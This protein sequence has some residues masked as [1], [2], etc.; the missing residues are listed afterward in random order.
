MATPMH[1]A[2]VGATPAYGK[3]VIDDEGMDDMERQLRANMQAQATAKDDVPMQDSSD[4]ARIPY[5][6]IVDRE[7][8]YQKRRLNRGMTPARVDAYSMGDQTP[9]A[10]VA[11]YADTLR[12]AQLNREADN[13]QWNI[14]LKQQ[15][16]AKRAAAAPAAPSAAPSS[17]AAPPRRRNRWGEQPAAKAPDL[18]DATPA[19]AG[20]GD[21]T[22]ARDSLADATPMVGHAW[23][24]TPGPSADMGDATPAGNRWDATPAAAPL[25]AAQPKRSRWDAT[26]AMGEATPGPSMADA[27]P[28]RKRSRCALKRV[29]GSC[30]LTLL[31]SCSLLIE[32]TR[33]MLP[34]SAMSSI[35]LISS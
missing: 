17:S 3:E 32:Q 22:P 6:R 25:G 7:T 11:T 8:D 30:Q 16:E 13:T 24:A 28:G 5:N 26:P 14:K 33:M 35:M 9:D 2:N 18:A 21:A 4:Q 12:R 19:H 20:I 23:D 1:G 34:M 10:S 27:T 31:I 15:E 29:T